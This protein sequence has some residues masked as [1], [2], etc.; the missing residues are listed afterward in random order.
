[1]DDNAQGWAYILEQE[2]QQQEATKLANERKEQ[3]QS[4]QETPSERERNLPKQQV[5]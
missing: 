5:A 2:Q 4:K 3:H 1:M